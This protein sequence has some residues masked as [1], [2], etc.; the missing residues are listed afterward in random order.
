MKIFICKI[1]NKLLSYNKESNS[2]DLV[3]I[4]QP[5]DIRN[6][7]RI[8]IEKEQKNKEKPDV[9]VKCFANNRENS[10]FLDEQMKGIIFKDKK[11]S[12]LNDDVHFLDIYWA[13][14]EDNGIEQ[15][16][17]FFPDGCWLPFYGEYGMELVCNIPFIRYLS[18]TKKLGDRKIETYSGMSPYYS[19]V[20]PD[21]FFERNEQRVYLKPEYRLPSPNL[22]EHGAR[23]SKY[24]HYENYRS[25]EKQTHPEKEIL[26]VQNKFTVEWMKGPVNY[27]P[28]IFLHY[29][30]SRYRDKYKIIYSR[31]NSKPL[32]GY[33]IDENTFCE[34]PDLAVA[35][36]YGITIFEESINNE[37]YNEAK[38]NLF[39]D[40]KYFIS[41][42]GG[43]SYTIPFFWDSEL[44]ILHIEGDESN[45]GAYS[46]NGFFSYIS[47]NTCK[48]HV[49]HSAE[50]LWADIQKNL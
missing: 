5:Y 40:T 4:Y 23:K 28:L 1:K 12:I 25:P 38:I 13:Q 11:C 29:L 15:F 30:F 37:N 50:Q 26:F 31:P 3:N 36:S 6:V 39:N 46:E 49:A 2:F 7:I 45:T 27:L 16:L 8:C 21:H 10:W 22:N 44:F 17:F 33:S 48:L 42:Q 43:S 41:V 24:E 34:Y 20:N 18:D 35:K 9:I 14:Q 19:F 47:D 32:T